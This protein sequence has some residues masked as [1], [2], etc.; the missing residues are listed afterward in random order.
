MKTVKEIID[1]WEKELAGSN[2]NPKFPKNIYFFEGESIDRRAFKK[3]MLKYNV[4]QSE[5]YI[6]KDAVYFR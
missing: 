2:P 1:N 4:P 3:F 5:Y 6:V